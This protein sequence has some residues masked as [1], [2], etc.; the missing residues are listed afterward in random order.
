[1]WLSCEATGF[2]LA[3][4]LGDHVEPARGG[5]SGE[6]MR[7]RGFDRIEWANRWPT[8]V[9]VDGVSRACG[10]LRRGRGERCLRIGRKKQGIR[11][12]KSRLAHESLN[13]D[14]SAAPAPLAFSCP[15]SRVAT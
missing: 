3:R 6:S 8:R 4:E 1:V 11:V 5:G 14:A 7:E 9:R 13:D 10:D 15:A 12:F 2:E